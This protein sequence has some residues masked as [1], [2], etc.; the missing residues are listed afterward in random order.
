MVMVVEV[1]IMVVVEVLMVKLV[2]VV[3][4]VL[5]EMMVEVKAVVVV[6][7]AALKENVRRS[8]VS[9]RGRP[10]EPHGPLGCMAHHMQLRVPEKGQR[11]GGG[12]WPY[13]NK[14]AEDVPGGP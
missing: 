5:V 11:L 3:V 9:R 1:V 14:E 13:A 10:W 2:C 4:E 12:I 7:V 6:V 8:L